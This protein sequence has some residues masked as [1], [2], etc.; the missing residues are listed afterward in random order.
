MQ[1]ALRTG[2]VILLLLMLVG[3]VAYHWVQRALVDAGVEELEWQGMRYSGGEFHL[4]RVSGVYSS[5]DGRL[6]F[7]LEAVRL[8]P[9]WDDGPRVLLL[10]VRDLD[11]EWEAGPE[12]TA[13]DKAK[14]VD[15]FLHEPQDWFD[16]S[17]SLPDVT[18]I[19]ALSVGLP[20]QERRC[21]L[22]GGLEIHNRVE[23]QRL[24][25]RADLRS[26]SDRLHLQ[27]K[28][29]REA[30]ALLLR[31]DLHINDAP[32][33]ELT[34]RWQQA[35]RGPELSG[36]LDIPSLP[37]SEMLIGLLQ[38]WSSVA[39][40]PIDLP[41][42]LNLRTR[43]SLQPLVH[44][45]SWQD[46]LDGT[47]QVE[48]DA[49]LSEPWMVDRIGSLSG[50]LAVRL[51]GNNGRWLLHEGKA[52]VHVE[53]LQLPPLGD[54]TSQLQPRSIDLSIRPSPALT[55]GWQEQLSLAVEARVEGGTAGTVTGQLHVTPGIAW[56]ARLEDARLDMRIAR[57]DQAGL[58]LRNVHARVPLQA[59]IDAEHF[60]LQFGQAASVSAALAS[61]AELGLA[62]SDVHVGLP[63]M[64]L[65]TPLND[66]AAMQIS[67]DTQIAASEV[68][69]AV[70]RP[71]GWS[72]QGALRQGRDGLSW[73]GTVAAVGGLGLD[74]A[75]VWPLDQP[76]RAE[77]QLQE[78]F[79]R[80]DNPLAAT[81]TDWPE[82]LTLATG[83][84][85]GRFDVSGVDS[86]ERLDGRFDA[87]GIGGIYDRA[88]FQGLNLPLDVAIARDAL[89]VKT[90]GL[91]L[92]SLNPGIELGPLSAQ[93]AYDATMPAPAQGRLTVRHAELGLLDGELS[94]QPTTIDLGEPRQEMVVDLRGVQLASLFEAY[95]AQGL[96]GRGTLDGTLPVS[97]VGGKVS[98]DSGS[99]RAREP[100]GV[101]QYRSERLS[102]LGRSN[103]GMRELAVALEDFR[104]SVLSTELDY[105]EDG[106]LI[107]GLRLEGSNPELQDGRPVH[108]NVNLEENIPALLASLQLSG[109][110][111]EIIQKR[112]QERLLQQRLVQ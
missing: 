104:Y 76:W 22:E 27:G 15:D 112:V 42:G 32:G 75:L 82:L 31:A 80:A 49:A 36:Q 90:D 3:L 72:L 11:L 73:S 93:L 84:L 77:V 13:S 30:E 54:I 70:L 16:A 85:R 18:R 78:V 66:P 29:Y 103:V 92:T 71:Q 94:V 4:D 81:L 56:Y 47:V 89:S 96:S 52:D 91:S 111:S 35:E 100:G 58:R 59:Q 28:A 43:W 1:R 86:L 12:R 37:D 69:H 34:A 6:Q 25:A 40:S 110:V 106:V 63:G 48:A 50:N 51:A 98:I 83:R 60:Q 26:G 20:C 10:D 62:L 19:H 61:H 7:E 107:L 23:D 38:P 53:Q 74:V 88:T 33:A 9:T 41:S 102:E 67:S 55:L 95:P 17:R 97:V 68:Q 21:Q 57:L 2:L 39:A 105:G 65:N 101:L 64:S 79:F 14:P 44:P 45:R 46:W 24:E 87:S 5:S 108:L 109:Q 8:A 99:V